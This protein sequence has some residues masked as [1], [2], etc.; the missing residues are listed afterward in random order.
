MLI[1]ALEMFNDNGYV[2]TGYV[3]SVWCDYRL[4]A[5]ISFPWS[6]IRNVSF[7]NKKFVIKPTD[8]KSP[9]TIRPPRDVDCRL[10][11]VLFVVLRRTVT[12]L[13]A[14]FL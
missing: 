2:D 9:V 3:L 12:V 10:V 13:I 8:R 5:K 7:S 6:E 14:S 1:S 11:S 4:A